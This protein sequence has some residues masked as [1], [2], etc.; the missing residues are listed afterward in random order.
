M[1]LFYYSR[2]L[3]SQKAVLLA[4]EQGTHKKPCHFRFVFAI[5]LRVSVNIPLWLYVK[6]M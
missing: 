1:A 2:P 6:S 4:W 3:V 5:A